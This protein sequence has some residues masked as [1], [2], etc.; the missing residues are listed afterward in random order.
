MSSG[1]DEVEATVHSAVRNH[2]LPI[3]AHLL[4]QVLVKLLLHKLQDG[5]PAKVGRTRRDNV[6]IV[7]TRNNKK[8]IWSLPII[9]V[10]FVPKAG[11]VGHRQLQTNSLLLNDCKTVEAQV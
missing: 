10:D 2:L 8:K 11:S 6:S 9:V 1:R 7:R 3:N 5:G 4:V